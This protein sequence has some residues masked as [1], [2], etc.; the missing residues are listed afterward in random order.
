MGSFA[1]QVFKQSIGNTEIA[2]SIFKINGL[3]L[4]GMADEPISPFYFL[5]E[6][7]HENVL[8]YIAAEINQNGVDAFQVIEQRGKG[9]RNTVQFVW[10]LVPVPRLL[11]QT[12]RQIFQSCPSVRNNMCIE[13]ARGST[14]LWYE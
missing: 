11:I 9:Y 14:K 4:C 12:H 5:F 2:F 1:L 7:A 8:P 6:V 3:T 13:V 10:W